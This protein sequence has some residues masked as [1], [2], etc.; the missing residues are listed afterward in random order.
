MRSASSPH[1][2]QA[3]ASA[4]TKRLGELGVEKLPSA[5]VER[6]VREVYAR[7]VLVD[8]KDIDEAPAFDSA[9]AQAFMLDPELRKFQ[10][11]VARASND[12]DAFERK[13]VEAVLGN[14]LAG[15]PGT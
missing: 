12:E 7:E 9:K 6:M 1:V 10:D 4:M 5:E 13:G 14:S 2:S 11:F 15:S 3:L 8:W